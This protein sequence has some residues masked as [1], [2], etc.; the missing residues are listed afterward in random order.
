MLSCQSLRCGWLN[1]GPTPIPAPRKCPKC[2]S[3]LEYLPPLHGLDADPPLN[4]H[5][6]FQR[7]TE[8]TE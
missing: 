2:G 1:T 3:S 6:A 8:V 4:E 5:R 7:A